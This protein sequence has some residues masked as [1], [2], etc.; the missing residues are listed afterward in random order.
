MLLLRVPDHRLTTVPSCKGVVSGS[1]S[2]RAKVPQIFTWHLVP[3]TGDLIPRYALRHLILRNIN[4]RKI[5][6][7]YFRPLL[8]A[9]EGGA[10]PWAPG[11]YHGS[12]LP[13]SLVLAGVR[14]FCLVSKLTAKVG[15]RDLHLTGRPKVWRRFTNSV[16]YRANIRVRAIRKYPLPSVP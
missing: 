11:G 13:P 10:C 2:K 5:R 4:G 15:Y 3:G 14:G 12:T 9:C 8:R 16:V 6:A 7:T 1:H